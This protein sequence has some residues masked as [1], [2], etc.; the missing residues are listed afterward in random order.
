[1]PRWAM[2]V[3]REGWDGGQSAEAAVDFGQGE[4]EVQGLQA[5][6]IFRARMIWSGAG[7]EDWAGDRPDG[8]SVCR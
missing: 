5:E 4:R 2:G 8:P 7:R 1:M 3:R 6:P